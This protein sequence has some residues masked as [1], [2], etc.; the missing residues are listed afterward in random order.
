[1]AFLHPIMKEFSLV[2]HLWYSNFYKNAIYLPKNIPF[3]FDYNSSQNLN[4]SCAVTKNKIFLFISN[5]ISFIRKSK[6]FLHM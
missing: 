3:Y 1:L 6:S 4:L 5:N 2:D